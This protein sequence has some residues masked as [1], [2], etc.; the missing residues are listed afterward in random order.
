[1]IAA[2][3]DANILFSAAWRE[4]SGI[5]KLRARPDVQR[6]TSPFALAEAER[7]LQLKKPVAVER[8]ARLMAQV[9]VSTATAPL[10]ADYGLPEK[11]WPI[12][13]AAVGSA[14]AVLLT[15]DIAHFGHL[16]GSEIKGVKILTVSMF[17]ADEPRPF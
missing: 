9:E 14:C 16:I 15:G 1:M 4:G 6:V 7:N 8:L 12:L 3:L 10:A 11:D 13:E 2:F 5:A 17:L